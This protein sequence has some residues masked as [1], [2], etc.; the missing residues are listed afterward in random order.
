[1]NDDLRHCVEH[2][3]RGKQ[4]DQS[5]ADAARQHPCDDGN[6]D[7]TARHPKGPGDSRSGAPLHGSCPDRYYKAQCPSTSGCPIEANVPAIYAPS[8]TSALSQAIGAQG[9]QPLGPPPAPN[10]ECPVSGAA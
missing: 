1:L 8:T 7:T 10:A 4:G 9:R 3:T 6:C 5:P 2:G